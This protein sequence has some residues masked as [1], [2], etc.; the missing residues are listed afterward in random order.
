MAKDPYQYFV[1][2]AR[3]LLEQLGKGV[4]EFEQGRGGAVIVPRLLRLAHTLKGAARVVKQG[5][6]ADDAH[7]IED[8]LAPFRD[9][10]AEVPSE[11]IDAILGL[12]DRM[13]AGVAAL[14]GPPTA[15]GRAADDSLQMIRAA[16]TEVDALLD[17]LSES[18]A[19]LRLL[20]SSVR[21]VDRVR[22][23]GDL[24][25]KQ[26][27]PRVTRDR[28][29]ANASTSAAVATAEELRQHCALLE[30]EYKTGLDQIDRELRQVREVAEQL[31]LTS[32]RTIFTALERAAR[33]AAQAVG[34][35]VTFQGVGAEVRLE[36][37]VLAS[38]QRAL[39]QAVRNAVAHGI[40][41][42]RD[43]QTAGKPP[44]G[45][46]VIEVARRGRF[47]R[48]RCTDDGRGVDLDAV[49][50]IAAER[51]L[52]AS[53]TKKLSA[54]DLMRLLLQGGISTATTVTEVSGRG[55][56]LDV[57]R[58]VAEQLH[59]EVAVH[60]E[61]GQGTTIELLVPLSLTSVDALIL[62]GSSGAA[63]MPLDVVRKTLRVSSHEISHTARG[64]SV[65]Y[66]GVVIPFVP[67]DRVLQPETGAAERRPDRV[68]SIVVVEGENGR[69]AVGIDRLLGASRIVLRPLPQLALAGAAIA[70]T[71]LDAEGVPQVVLDP[72]GLVAAA[73]DG[74]GGA[75]AQPVARRPLLVIDDSLT[76]RMLEQ[77]ILESAGYEVEVATSG[78]EALERARHTRYALFL[79]DV[80]M[81]GMDGFTFIE[82][83]QVDPVLR[84]VPAILVTSRNSPQDLQRGRE[85]G[86]RGY[87]IKSEF[88][89]AALLARIKEL[90]GTP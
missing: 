37:D 40:E 32:A 22:D 21:S 76:T 36:A 64:E 33:D 77:S 70:G 79:V 45:R 18:Q 27:A 26:L 67:L 1:P 73:I 85:V 25:V 2:E 20:R 5:E 24:L 65:I 19:Q 11:T 13:G 66:D 82:R 62:E 28:G 12:I 72:D 89:Q 46:I 41:G 75:V 38:V 55:V 34:R 54:P 61:A 53:E 56:G 14:V 59:G 16:A 48:F 83:A 90:L 31:R 78:E 8:A 57:M 42:A 86:A 81:P 6:I 39:V 87:M 44:A 9:S 17:G 52:S 47:A 71:C 29:A 80:E 49:R 84:D 88:N 10:A 60:T 50:R 30:R 3:D 51:G 23:L 15:A 43:R 63:A 35:Q 68:W 58:E 4:L 7:A 74:G 69:A